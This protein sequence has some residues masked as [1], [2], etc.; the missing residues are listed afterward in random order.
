MFGHSEPGIFT[1]RAERIMTAIAAQAAVAIENANLYQTSQRDIEARKR[2]EHELQRLNE[3][4]EQ[5]VNERAQSSP[6]TSDNSR[7]PNAVSIC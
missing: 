7:I 1:E 6:R 5:R 3:T 4:L 2:A